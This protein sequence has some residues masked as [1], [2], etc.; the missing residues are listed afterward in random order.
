MACVSGRC[1]GPALPARLRQGVVG[2][3]AVGEA[4]VPADE[5]SAE[6]SGFALGEINIE[7]PG[8]SCGPELSCLVNHFEGRVTCPAGQ[9]D[10]ELGNCLTLDGNPVSVPVPPQLESRPA[11]RHVICSCR[12]DGPVRGADYCSCPSG[13]QCEELIV[14]RGRE[15]DA[16]AGSYCTYPTAE[17]GDAPGSL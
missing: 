9:I 15:D 17:A 14:G 1:V 3:A 10:D 16:Y 6:F 7:G 13:M 5:S 11:E 4:C 2:R 12:C 8:G